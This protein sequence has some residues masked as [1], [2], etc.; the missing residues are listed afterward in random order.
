M[1]TT[2]WPARI[3]ADATITPI[4]LDAEE[5]HSGGARLTTERAE[6]YADAAQRGAAI[7][8]RPSLTGPGERS[9]MLNLR[10]PSDTKRRLE[11]VAAAQGRR[12]S[13]VVREA[14]DRY[15]AEAA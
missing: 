12:P 15:L 4:D 11:V 6:R 8:G 10:V 14:L 1:I 13:D 7:P 3:A 5:F 2:A 9:P